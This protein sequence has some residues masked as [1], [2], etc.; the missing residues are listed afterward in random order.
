[1]VQGLN[2]SE[3]WFFSL[4]RS[5]PT[6]WAYHTVRIKNKWEDKMALCGIEVS[7]CPASD[8]SSL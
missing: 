6:L 3:G 8:I 1:M 7:E 2:N 5:N 4:D